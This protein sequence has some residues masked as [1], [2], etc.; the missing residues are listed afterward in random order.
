MRYSEQMPRLHVAAN[1]HII[2]AL[3]IA[4]RFGGKRP[5]VDQL[6]EAFGMSR[7]TAYRWR[8]AWDAVHGGAA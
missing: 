8:Q 1:A 3:R 7:A 5:S 2:T 4:K 6:R